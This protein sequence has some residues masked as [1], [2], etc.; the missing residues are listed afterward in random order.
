MRPLTSEGQQK[1]VE[2]AQRYNV[3]TDAVLTLLHALVNGRGTM[4][5]FDHPE[6]GGRGQWMQGGMVMVGDMFNH[7]LKAKVTELCTAL[8]SLFAADFL[9]DS[10]AGGQSQS[11]GV[12]SSQ[13]QPEIRSPE[14]SKAT[15]RVSLFV[16]PPAGSPTSWWP[17]GLGTPAATGSQNSVR[18]AFFPQSRRLAI[19][20][21]GHVT[22]YDTQDHQI[23][24]VSQ[25]QGS[26][27]TLTFT[28][29][30][31]IV[32]VNTLPVVKT[33]HPESA[34]SEAVPQTAITPSPSS[35][36]PHKTAAR[37]TDVLSMIE[38]LAEL[39]QKGIL[40]EEEFAAKKAE[41]LARI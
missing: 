32:A 6:F 4:A 5:Q 18:Y 7:T 9:S 35:P 27:S 15:P 23:S 22:L 24:G 26:G 10:P 38:R 36:A 19:E 12:P 25:Q 21:H 13:L 17:A 41:L 31:G 2:L 34:S 11:Q 30:H 29:Q 3:S 40:S 39:R 37:E 20:I 33:D 1:I 8:V 28:S 14:S 16:A